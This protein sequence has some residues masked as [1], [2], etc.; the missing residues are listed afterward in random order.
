MLW[1]QSSLRMLQFLS[2][3]GTGDVYNTDHSYPIEDL[4]RGSI[5]FELGGLA[6]NNDKR[7]FVEMFT[8]W[9]WL[10]K[11]QQGIEDEKLKHVL[12][13]EDST[14]SWKTAKKTTWSRKSSGRSGNTGPP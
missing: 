6:N 10:Y 4:L 5:V 12:V 2:Y 14:T 8:L 7:F 9:Y 3:G 1:K 11:E 13:F